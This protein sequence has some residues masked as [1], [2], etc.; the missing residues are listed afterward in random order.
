MRG[1]VTEEEKGTM[2]EEETEQ[3]RGTMTEEETEAG[4][5][6]ETGVGTG[7]ELG[8]EAEIEAG[9]EVVLE[10]EAGAE[11]EA[12]GAEAETELEIEVEKGAEREVVIGAEKETETAR[13]RAP[14]RQDERVDGTATVLPFLR[15]KR[16]ERTRHTRQRQIQWRHLCLECRTGHL[17]IFQAMEET[18]NGN[19]PWTEWHQFMLDLINQLE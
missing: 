15:T 1:T 13:Q 3:L 9:T 10:T 16:L 17:V 18:A 14:G 2:T 5:E 11:I 8:L 4:R 12:A 19:N 6:A 7:T